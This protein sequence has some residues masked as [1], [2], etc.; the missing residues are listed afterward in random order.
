MPK[1]QNANS[2]QFD[3]K[4]EAFVALAGKSAGFL[5][6]TLSF[7]RNDAFVMNKQ[8]LLCIHICMSITIIFDYF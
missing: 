4:T 2:K 5:F 1:R 7:S 3:Q 6:W 8:S